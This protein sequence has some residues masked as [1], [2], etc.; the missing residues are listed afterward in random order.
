MT[1]N[2]SSQLLGLA[3]GRFL[4]SLFPLASLTTI[5]MHIL[6]QRVLKMNASS[7]LISQRCCVTWR[8]KF[9][10]TAN[11]AQHWP[12]PEPVQSISHT[13]VFWRPVSS[14]SSPMSTQLCYLQEVLWSGTTFQTDAW[15]IV[16]GVC[17]TTMCTNT[18]S[19]YRFNF[20]GGHEAE[21]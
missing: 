6:S 11:K 1:V 19:K 16:Y 14:P 12:Y 5:P 7:T 8:V 3:S 21:R 4:R 13:V 15:H 9:I 17:N 10:I 20:S 2:L 18:Q